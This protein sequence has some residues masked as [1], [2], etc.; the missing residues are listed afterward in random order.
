LQ[1]PVWMQLVHLFLADA[2]WIALI[3]LAASALRVSAHSSEA[4][5]APSMA[6]A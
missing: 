2:V 6:R 3:L 5:P 1:A 4:Q